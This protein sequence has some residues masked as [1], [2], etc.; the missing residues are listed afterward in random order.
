METIT[1]GIDARAYLTGWLTMVT[2]MTVKDIH[3]VPDDKW[4]VVHGGCARPAN[5]LIADV[6][7]NLRYTTA[8]VKGEPSDAYNHMGEVAEQMKDK[9]VAATLLVE[10]ADMLAKAV[11]EA[12][13]EKL[14]S[15]EMAPWQMPTPVFT[16]VHISV[17]HIWYHDGQ[18]NYIHGLCGDSNV[19]WM[20]E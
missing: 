7:T 12:T 10:A 6:V 1:T 4:N 20:T 17:S 11:T 15:I 8:A 13:D 5:E 16:L 3:A 18:L 19:H 2:H 14:N 9:S